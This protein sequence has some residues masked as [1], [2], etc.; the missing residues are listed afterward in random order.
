MLKVK[1]S[2]GSCT[3]LVIYEIAKKDVRKTN[4]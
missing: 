1:S 4:K 2:N 3:A